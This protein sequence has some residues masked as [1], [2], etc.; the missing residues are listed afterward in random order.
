MS[1]KKKNEPSCEQEY[2]ELFNFAKEAFKKDFKT[3]YNSFKSVAKNGYNIELANDAKYFMAI[4]L[5]NELG[6]KKN[7]NE[8]CRLFKE[9][10][11]RPNAGSI[12]EQKTK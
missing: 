8:A 10:F 5:I 3:S 12:T 2:R 6:V 1:T 9:V 4:H 7:S 11:T